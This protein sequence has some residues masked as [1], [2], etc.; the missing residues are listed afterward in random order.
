[1]LLMFRT[2]PEAAA[3][4]PR[5]WSWALLR[6]PRSV[7]MATSAVLVVATTVGLVAGVRGLWL[8]TRDRPSSG[9]AAAFRSDVASRGPVLLADGRP[10]V[11]VY[12]YGFWPEEAWLSKMLA[13][14]PGARFSGSGPELSMVGQD[15]HVVRARVERQA[16]TLQGPVA[17]C[18]Y[19]IGPGESI[20]LGLDTELISW[21]WGV[22]ASF[23]A[24]DEAQVVLQVDGNRIPMEV[25]AGVSTVVAPVNSAVTEVTLTSSDASATVCLVGLAFG[26][27]TPST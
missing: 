17:D 13:G 1:M 12:S 19:A 11:D 16:G 9:W 14:V 6:A 25:S 8:E 2:S 3:G 18:G 26:S 15:G 5:D 24:G 7:V 21:N 23:V 20:D 4:Q 22:E 10:P 27:V